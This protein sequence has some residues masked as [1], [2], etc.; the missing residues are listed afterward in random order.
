MRNNLKDKNKNWYAIYTKSRAEKK[1]WERLIESDFEAYLPLITKV[2]QW[3][4]RK[5]KVKVPLINSYVFVN[6]D[7]YGLHK[8]MKVFGTVGVL[9][10]IGKPAIVKD[11]EIKNLKILTEG[12]ANIKN[13]ASD[14][15][16][17]IGYSIEVERGP[18]LGIKGKCARIN[19]KNSIVVE[20][21]T[22]G[23][24]FSVDIPVSYIKVLK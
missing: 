22:L 13:I 5:K 16:I 2:R 7:E 20:L 23:N 14:V 9:K 10:H 6:V 4:D 18:F 15:N 8:V 17:E 1:V 12:G 3:S 21:E 11:Y 19:G 24:F